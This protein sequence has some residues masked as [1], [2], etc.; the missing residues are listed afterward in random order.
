MKNW[1]PA[2]FAATRYVAYNVAL[3]YS[4]WLVS[5]KEHWGELSSWDYRNV[6]VILVLAALTALGAV[7]N[8]SWNEARKGEKNAAPR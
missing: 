6:T 4:G 3:A 7:M 2:W 8:G 5:V 1:F